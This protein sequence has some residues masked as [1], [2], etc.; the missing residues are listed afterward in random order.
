ML[1]LTL[2]ECSSTGAT[3]DLSLTFALTLIAGTDGEQQSEL[4]QTGVDLRHQR[5]AKDSA[6][7]ALH[8]CPLSCTQCVYIRGCEQTHSRVTS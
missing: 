3:H 1:F 8:C 2:S 5:T 4:C 7:S 6:I